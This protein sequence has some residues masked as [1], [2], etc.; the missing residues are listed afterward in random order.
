MYKNNRINVVLLKPKLHY[1]FIQEPRLLAYIGYQV[2]IISN[3]SLGIHQNSQG[4]SANRTSYRRAVE[5]LR[6]LYASVGGSYASGDVNGQYT[7]IALRGKEEEHKEL[8]LKIRDEW[9]RAE[10]P[11]LSPPA[12]AEDSESHRRFLVTFSNWLTERASLGIISVGGSSEGMKS[13]MYEGH[14]QKYG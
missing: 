9:L 2:D 5:D 4:N 7:R 3:V 6:A 10:L 13:I 12:T 14:G 8:C 11:L 1:K